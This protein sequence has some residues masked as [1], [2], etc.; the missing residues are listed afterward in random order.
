[1]STPAVD[2]CSRR[3]SVLPCTVGGRCDSRL[4]LR[5]GVQRRRS[6]R[7]ETPCSPLRSP[8]R[9][10]ASR[11]SSRKSSPVVRFYPYSTTTSRRPDELQPQSCRTEPSPYSSSICAKTSSILETLRLPMSLTAFFLSFCF[12]ASSSEMRPAASSSCHRLFLRRFS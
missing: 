7:K 11:S 12:M 5:S 10:D 3:E 4:K 1:M 9:E 8:R 6:L 2:I